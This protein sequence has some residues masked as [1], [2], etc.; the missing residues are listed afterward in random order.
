MYKDQERQTILQQI[1]DLERLQLNEESNHSPKINGLKKT[2]SSSS[3]YQTQKNYNEK[4]DHQ[5]QNPQDFTSNILEKDSPMTEIKP[6]SMSS[7]F[8]QLDKLPLSPITDLPLNSEFFWTCK[9]PLQ[10]SQVRL[11][12]VQFL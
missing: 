8:S 11:L 6:E 3:V 4:W 5:A 2:D 9:S 1:I 10:S 7:T 12:S